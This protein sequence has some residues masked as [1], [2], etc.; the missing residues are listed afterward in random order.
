MGDFM[1]CNQCNEKYKSALEGLPF[2][3]RK[4]SEAAA[5]EYV[6]RGRKM[7]AMGFYL[8][9]VLR[10]KPDVERLGRAILELALQR[11]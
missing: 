8:R 11:A 9:P 6:G 1:T 3:A 5:E 7:E 4:M 2:E 10:E